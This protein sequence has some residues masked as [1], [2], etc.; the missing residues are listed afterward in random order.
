M[1]I[2]T[3]PEHLKNLLHSLK[4]KP[5]EYLGQNFLI[6][7]DVL[8]EIIEVAK[9]QKGET[10]VEIG[11]G[12]GVLT[13]RLAQASAKI[14]AVEKDERYVGVLKKFFRE[15][16]NI[17]IIEKDILQFNFDNISGDY[18]IVS[19]IPYY[20]TSHLLQIL[21]ALKHKPTKIVFMVQKEVAERL[22]AGPGNLSVLGISVQIFADVSIA[23]V[24]PKENFW[25]KPKVDS[26]IIVIEP[27]NKFP[28]ISDQ[29]LFFRILKIA[30]A[31]KRKQIHNSLANGF[32]W[33]KEKVMKVLSDSQIDPLSRPQDLSIEDWIRLYKNAS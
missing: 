10:V 13:Q 16:K 29:K 27:K 33:D 6:S 9:I 5:K 7:E 8:N 11:P 21:L 32:K 12:L 4:I 30:F 23:A 28:Q 31:G 1:N 15:S 17:D 25:P 24:V 18:K 19:N 22:V 20:L 26:S 14:I 3:D 2:L